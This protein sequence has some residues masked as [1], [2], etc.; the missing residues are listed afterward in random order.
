MFDSRH[1]KTFHA[2]VTAGSYSAAARAL[3]YTQPAITQQMKA[4]ERSVGTP[5]FI[6]V[7]R[8][9]RLTEAGE[10]LAR[11]AETILDSLTTAQQQ[12]S[13]LTRLRS[14]R[15]RVCAFPSASA[16]LIPEALA[17]L[18]AA[19]PGVRVE[20]LE[21]EP[22]DSIHRLVRGECDITLA[23]TYP[24]LREQV[25]DEVVETRLMEDQLTILMPTGHPLARRRAVQLADLTEERWIAG[26]LRCR[27][28]FL[29]ECAELGFAPDIAFTTDDNLVVQSLVAEGLGV[30]MMP[31]LV[32]SFL[33]HEK[34]TGRALDPAI[35]RQVSAYVLREHL[36][37]PATA[38]V[39]DE[40]RAVAARRVGC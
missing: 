26:C 6:R 20:L 16:T 30:A 14:G 12:M 36:R 2:V 24:G 33:R 35:R 13:S 3:G 21:G 19:H 40:L 5:L 32:L 31:G 9:M 28:N 39:L 25:P 37:V 15:V 8:R 27:T 23:F 17:G 34:I 18:A 1:I 11:H 22:P 29:H 38:L 7:G 10:A 4:L